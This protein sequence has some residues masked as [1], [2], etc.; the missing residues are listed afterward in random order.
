MLPK[1]SGRPEFIHSQLKIV[2]KCKLHDLGFEVLDFIF[3][4]S[5]YRQP[6][7]DI[8]NNLQLVFEALNHLVLRLRCGPL[9]EVNFL[10]SGI[11]KFVPIKLVGWLEIP[12][13]IIK[14]LI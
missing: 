5:P 10:E 13:E 14:G 6:D 12:D 11:D 8:V 7:Q 9:L 1:I 4:F 2:S 3:N